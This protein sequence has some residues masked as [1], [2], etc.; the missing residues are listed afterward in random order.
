MKKKKIKKHKRLITSRFFS[1][2]IGI[3]IVGTT[4]YVANEY[5]SF[6][7]LWKSLF[8]IHYKVY[9]E[10]GIKLPTQ[11]KI[12]GIDVSHHQG[13]INWQMVRNMK[14]EDVTLQFTFIKATEGISFLDKRFKE[15]WRNSKRNDIVRGAYH[16]FNP[17]LK[18]IAQANN[19]IRNVKLQAGDLPPVIDI[20][21]LGGVS[22]KRLME[23]LL[24]FAKQLENHYGTKP[25]I[26]T[27]HDF[28]KLNFDT[29][30]QDYPLW[31]AHY[32]K[33]TPNHKKWSFWQH[34]DKG[35]VSGINYPVD[36]NVFSGD[37]AAFQNI[38]IQ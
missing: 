12:N 27:Y 36:F 35:K 1:L 24:I 9:D 19:F 29:T 28:Y 23:G 3:W 38:L 14:D 20:E 31:I 2:F 8:P 33:E 34:N 10:F 5:Y 18:G 22:P 7:L 25:I 21:E 37:S 16:Y 26:Y 32:Y 11:Y 4:I 15:N 30:F 13:S 17:D 6:Q